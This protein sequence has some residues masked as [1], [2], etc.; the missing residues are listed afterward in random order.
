MVENKNIFIEG[1]EIGEGCPVF[2]IAEIGVN[3]NGK[4]ALAHDMIDIVA[5][6]G[7]DCV[8]FQTFTANE[9][10]NNP[11]DTYE[12]IS[13]GE[14]VKES[15]LEMFRRL[16]FN[17]D[18]FN[19]L[20]IHARERNLIPLSTPTDKKAIDLLNNLD[21]HAYKIGSDDLIYSPFLS[22][23]ASNK[24]PIIISTGMAE[25]DDIDRALKVIEDAGNEDIVILHCISQY[26]TPVENINL[27]R[28]I[29]LRK[30]YPNIIIGYSDHSWGITSAIGAVALGAKVLEKHFTLDN[31][32]P[33]PDHRFSANPEQ[34]SVLVSEVRTIEKSLG[35][36]KIVLT[37]E[38]KEMASLCHRSI[39]AARNLSVGDVLVEDDLVYQRPGIGLMPY[40]NKSIIGRKLN[41]NILKGEL[42]SF[43]QLENLNE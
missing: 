2:I 23:V 13:Q 29:M 16:E 36:N 25:T 3:H 8:K 7:C 9:F 38:D 31:D 26:P 24:K 19:E 30:R 35:S 32:M 18:E 33:G 4:A 34:L 15:M 21:C 40:E 43:C 14:T 39:Y 17:Y 11:N 28:M 1:R 22:L 12:Y 41:K 37:S 42:L 5:D 10:C 27:N 20:F 6:S